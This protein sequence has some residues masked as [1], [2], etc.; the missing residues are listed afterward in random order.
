[1]GIAATGLVVGLIVGLTGVGGAALMTPV[2]VLLFQ[3]QPLAAIGSDLVASLFMKPVG[4]VVHWQRGNVHWDIVKWLLVGSLP[5]GFGGVFAIRLLGHGSVLENRIQTVLGATLLLTSLGI[6]L[7]TYIEARRKGV[8]DQWT[9]SSYLE[10][11]P[12]VTIAIGALVG[13]IVGMTSVGSGSLMMA[14]LMV[15]YPT[16]NARRLI[17]TDLAQAVP[18]VG[19]AAV[20]HVLFGDFKPGLTLSILVGSI[21]GVY[22]GARFSA[23]AP[24]IV[25]RPILVFSLVASA[26]KLI[27]VSTAGLGLG[28]VVMASVLPPLWGLIDAARWTPAHWELARESRTLWLRLQALGTLTIGIGPPVAIAYFSRVRPRLARAATGDEH[29]IR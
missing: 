12:L 23:N 13:L 1:M 20:A 5:T 22:V 18:L 7:K 29:P 14:L 10:I 28:L 6:V 27:D 3:V 19:S 15:T 25:M 24:D 4:V 2:L 9:V 26:L 21:P 11:R 17:G 16:L 8:G